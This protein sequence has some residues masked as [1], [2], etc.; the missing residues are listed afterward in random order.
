MRGQPARPAHAE[1]CSSTRP[2]DQQHAARRRTG[3]STV[4]R[5]EDPSQRKSSRLQDLVGLT[6][7]RVLRLPPLDLGQLVTSRTRPGA[8]GAGS[9]TARGTTRR[10]VFGAYSFLNPFPSSRIWRR[11]HIRCGPARSSVQSSRARC[12]NVQVYL[13]F[14]G[15]PSTSSMSG[16]RQVERGNGADRAGRAGLTG[17][18]RR[19]RSRRQLSRFP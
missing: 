13:S 9:N 14:I 19:D 4:A 18:V 2:H 8:G 7:V 1:R 3:R 17:A 15:P 10:P 16:V 5:V 11:A 6:K 12:H